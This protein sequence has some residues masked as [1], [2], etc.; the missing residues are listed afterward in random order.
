MSEPATDRTPGTG[1]GLLDRLTPGLTIYLILLGLVL[2]GALF[3]PGFRSSENL[4]NV[5]RPITLLGIVSV[6]VTFI[7]IGGHYVDL[8]IP[9]L[10][11]MTGIVSIACL[12]LGLAASLTAG[13]GSGLLIGLLNGAVIGYLRVNPILW[14]LS[15]A[16]TLDGILRWVQSGNQVYPDDSSGPGAAFVWLSRAEVP[17]EIP[18]MTAL[19]VLL[20]C[21][22]QWLLRRTRFGALLRLTGSAYEVARATGVRVRRVVFLS[23][24]LSSFTTSIAGLFLASMS[25]LGTF[26]NGA[27]Y[28]FNAITAVVL[29]GVMLA[30]GQ[31]SVLG[32]MA[33][34]LVIGLL[35]N[36]MT[37]WGWDAFTQLMVKGLVF[38]AAV[39]IGARWTRRSG[40]ED[41]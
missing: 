30:G 19:L 35:C 29:G 11:A 36:I 1:R 20:A 40:R 9:S 37:L 13:I 33:G 4:L 32:A 6:G 39:G 21:L 18:L 27:G 26:N 41:V 24:L 3:S 8:S 38:I 12:P 34:V 17:G 23:F 22:G 14:T 16:F 5:V 7:A 2:A 31:G 10:M 15:V 25:K 28:D